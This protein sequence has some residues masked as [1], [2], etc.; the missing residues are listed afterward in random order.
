MS[1]LKEKLHMAL[2]C[3]QSK[4]ICKAV[5]TEYIACL[6]SSVTLRCEVQHVN[7]AEWKRLNDTKPATFE[8]KHALLKIESM[9]K[10]SE[11]EYFCQA[12][13]KFFRSKSDPIT[14]RI[15]EPIPRL[16]F[17]DDRVKLPWNTTQAKSYKWTYIGEGNGPDK[18][19]ADVDVDVDVDDQNTCTLTIKNYKKTDTGTYICRDKET[20]EQL[21]AYSLKTKYNVI[22][23]LEYLHEPVDEEFRNKLI[24]NTERLLQTLPSHVVKIQTPEQRSKDT[25]HRSYKME[26]VAYFTQQR[27]TAELKTMENRDKAGVCILF[28]NDNISIPN[29]SFSKK[30][31]AISFRTYP[32]NVKCSFYDECHKNYWNQLLMECTGNRQDSGTAKDKKQGSATAEIEQESEFAETR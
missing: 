2:A 8:N 23:D 4:R 30:H 3:I 18:D 28:L 9:D 11:G 19:L 27:N 22:V 32:N 10:E 29:I 1:S 12:S 14:L 25:S 26:V 16:E 31:I 24:D 7:N 17:E 15:L 13:L 6:R 20:D 5:K 21:A